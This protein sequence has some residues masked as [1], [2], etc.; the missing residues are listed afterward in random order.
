VN[1]YYPLPRLLC[2][3]GSSS[4]LAPPIVTSLDVSYKHDDWFTNIL[5][6]AI[7]LQTFGL[8]LG[9]L[10]NADGLVQSMLTYSS[11]FLREYY[12]E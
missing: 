3:R 12:K 7:G 6:T 2:K 1:F 5:S 10:G 11:K 8:P 9:H 4:P